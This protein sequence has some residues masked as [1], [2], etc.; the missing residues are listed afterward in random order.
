[1]GQKKGNKNKNNINPNNKQ[2]QQHE[3][4]CKKEIPVQQ[5]KIPTE[6]TNIV[7][8][9]NNTREELGNPNSV[10]GNPNSVS[11]TVDFYYRE[12]I[13]I[14]NETLRNRLSELT[15]DNN[16]LITENNGL[17][18]VNNELRSQLQNNK[19]TIEELEKE[20]EQLKRRIQE[21]ENE[22]KELKDENKKLNKEINGL[23]EENKE[24]KNE[25]KILKEE[26]KELKDENKNIKIKQ[27]FAD[28]TK[29]IFSGMYDLFCTPET[30]IYKKS[31]DNDLYYLRDHLFEYYNKTYLN[32]KW[33][34]VK[35]D[36]DNWKNIFDDVLKILE[37]EFQINDI[38]VFFEIIKLREERNIFSH[39]NEKI[40]YDEIEYI[41]P[42][43]AQQ[44]WKVLN[45]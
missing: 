27:K 24:L 20:N 13:L 8:T 16:R 14:E 19:K 10:L 40:T 32:N 5:N 38:N 11:M 1:M 35:K 7:S 30:D 26:V 43:Y 18:A 12:K 3:T 31:K 37:V 22:V 33:S 45:E 6:T 28:N 34:K 29:N 39:S 25:V 36:I 15:R 23:K 42:N 44:I 2:C 9:P 41:S 4:Q 17:N 21:L